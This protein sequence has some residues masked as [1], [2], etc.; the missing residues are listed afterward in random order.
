MRFCFGVGEAGAYPN[1]SAVIGRWIPAAKR[2]RAWGTVW[3]TSQIGAALSPLLV[4]PIQVR[5]GWRASFFVF[6]TTGLAWSVTW[7]LWFR[8]S[9][10]EKAG[11]TEQELRE[12]GIARE[13]EPHAVRWGKAL[14]L[15]AMWRMAAIC[16]C[17]AYAQG[18][19]QAWL[20]TYLVRGRGFTEAALLFSSFTYL[21]RAAANALGGI[22]GDWLARQHG[23][24]KARRSIGVAGQGSAALFFTAA[25]LSP[26]GKWAL[27]FISLAYGGYLFQQPNFC[28]LCLDVGRK[29]AGAVFGVMNTAANAAAALCAVVFGTIVGRLGNYNL[30]FI[31][32]IGLLCL[33]ALLW[34]Q[35][36]PI[37][38]L[39]PESLTPA[40]ATGRSG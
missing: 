34:M 21:I 37:R 24:R 11:V 12:I 33:G 35:V 38:E 23:L 5:Y 4:V 18:F 13:S 26:S 30:P 6:G 10:H 27:L 20:Q 8:D 15:P 31:P 25:V 1:S 19:F 28:A 29:N 9:P 2:T 7:Y 36:D 17:Y 16:A 40:F 32:M 14:R 22:A 39:F 3:M